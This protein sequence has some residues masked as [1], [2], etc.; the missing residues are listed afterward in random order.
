MPKY[1]ADNRI[2]GVAFVLLASVNAFAL[3]ANWYA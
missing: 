2:I 3:Q 1:L